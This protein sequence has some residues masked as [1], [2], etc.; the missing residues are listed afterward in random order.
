MPDLFNHPIIYLRR[1]K[2]PTCKTCAN[3][4][5][6]FFSPVCTCAK[7]LEHYNRLNCTSVEYAILDDVRGTPSGPVITGNEVEP[8]ECRW[9]KAR[10]AWNKRAQ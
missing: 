2:T 3:Y 10:E 6:Q 7:Y 8:D 5:I 4:S 9:D 1:L